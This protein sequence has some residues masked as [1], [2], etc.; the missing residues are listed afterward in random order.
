[1]DKTTA[2]TIVDYSCEQLRLC[3]NYS[4]RGMF[5]RTTT[6]VIG[7]MNDFITAL[8]EA[9]KEEPENIE[10]DGVSTDSMGLDTIFY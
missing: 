9:T 1:M 3:E 6:G 4:G 10:L 7:F 2:E 5:G 8:V